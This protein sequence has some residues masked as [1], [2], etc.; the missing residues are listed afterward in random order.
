MVLLSALPVSGGGKMF[1]KEAAL[2]MNVV[3]LSGSTKHISHFGFENH[4][5][6]KIFLHISYV[7]VC[8]PRDE[9]LVGRL[10]SFLDP[11]GIF[12]SEI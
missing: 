7:C 3:S 8:G 5:Y 10:R 4:Y 1:S 9:N 6:P 12:R 11:C 2:E